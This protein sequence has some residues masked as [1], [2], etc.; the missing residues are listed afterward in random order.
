VD[1]ENGDAPGVIDHTGTRTFYNP[2][3]LCTTC[4]YQG[5]H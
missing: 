4:H 3:T 5:K 1:L 2:K